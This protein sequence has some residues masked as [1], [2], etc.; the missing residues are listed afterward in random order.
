MITGVVETEPILI[1]KHAEDEKD[2]SL[3]GML[4]INCRKENSSFIRGY[5]NSQHEYTTIIETMF[6]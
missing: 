4:L 6:P 1:K 2:E 5:I 3:K